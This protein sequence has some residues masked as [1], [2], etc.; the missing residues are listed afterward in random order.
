MKFVEIAMFLFIFNMTIAF[1]NELNL[2]QPFIYQT[3]G[4]G[5]EDVASGREKIESTVGEQ[6]NALTAALNWLVEN[7][8]LVIQA[9]TGFIKMFGNATIFSYGMY[10]QLLCYQVDCSFGSPMNTFVGIL[11]GMTMFTYTVAIIQLAL[12]RSMKEGV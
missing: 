5:T 7:V 1:V 3:G 6:Q 11:Y 12:G 2:V 4:W 9:I 10:T 8:R